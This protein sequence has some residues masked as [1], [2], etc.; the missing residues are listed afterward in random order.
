MYGGFLKDV[1]KPHIRLYGPHSPKKRPVRVKVLSW[2]GTSAIGAK[3]INVDF[4]VDNNPIWNADTEMWQQCWDD[5]ECKFT[6]YI[7]GGRFVYGRNHEKSITTFVRRTIK[8]FFPPDQFTVTYECQPVE[9]K[10]WVYR[11]GD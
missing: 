4:D 7:F 1:P 10:T 11:E 9:Q 5:K 2:V 3:H 6:T 8:E